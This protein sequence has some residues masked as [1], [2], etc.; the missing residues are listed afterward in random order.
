MPTA[1]ITGGK[2]LNISEEKAKKILE[3]KN[4]KNIEKD[5]FI[6]LGLKNFVALNQIK[7]VL[8]NE[9][10]IDQIISEER[11]KKFA[12]MIRDWNDYV[13]KCKKEDVET[14][15]KRMVK[16]GA[17]LLFKARMNKPMEIAGELYENLMTKFIPFFEKN[18]N[19]WWSGRENYQDVIPRAEFKNKSN[20]TGW[21][22]LGEIMQK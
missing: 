12:E 13:A 1:I 19:E 10:D 20:A 22:T 16:S 5:R 15:S 7:Q 8:F 9:K 17:F 21:K 2:Q 11:Q 3:Y 6:D 18:K 14:K 4:D